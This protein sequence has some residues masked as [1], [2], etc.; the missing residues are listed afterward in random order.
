MRRLVPVLVV[1]ALLH[2]LGGCA[3]QATTATRTVTARP[4]APAAATAEPASPSAATTAQSDNAGKTVTVY[5][6]ASLTESFNEMA[7]LFSAENGGARVSFNFANSSQLRA[8]IEQGAPADVFASANE[9]EMKTLVEGGMIAGEP[10]IFA[11][12]RL[13]VI[14]PKANPGR[15]ESVQD[16]GKPGVKFVAAGS[17]VPVGGYFLQVLDTMKADPAYGSDFKDKVMRNFVSE[18]TDVKQVVAKVQ[19]G[20]GDAGVVYLTDVTPKVAPNLQ[21]IEIPDALNVIAKYPIAVT[22]NASEGALGQAFV[23]FILSAEGQA[24]LKNLGFAPAK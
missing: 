17:A 20:E 8:Q 22:K 19:L 15:I 6:A 14:L 24:I 2:A 12:N 5:A 3:S 18:E 9:R 13:V 11:R 21:V 10:Q 16:L 23:S 4:I 1:L 7:D